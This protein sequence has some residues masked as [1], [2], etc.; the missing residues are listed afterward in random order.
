MERFTGGFKQGFGRIGIADKGPAKGKFKLSLSRVSLPPQTNKQPNQESNPKAKFSTSAGAGLGINK[1]NMTKTRT[2]SVTA[3][4]IMRLPANDE[5]RKKTLGFSF[6]NYQPKSR[7]SAKAT[8]NTVSNTTQV[9][10]TETKLLL[11]KFA[12]N[13]VSK[14]SSAGAAATNDKVF[15]FNSREKGALPLAARSESNLFSS[16]KRKAAQDKKDA[17]PNKSVRCNTKLTCKNHSCTKETGIVKTAGPFAKMI[18]SSPFTTQTGGMKT[19]SNNEAI[20]KKRSSLGTSTVVDQV[21]KR[22]K[23]SANMLSM[24]GTSCAYKVLEHTANKTVKDKYGQE[25]IM[26]PMRLTSDPHFKKIFFRLCV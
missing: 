11:D 1:Q 10:S 23:T 20:F 8:C 7:D 21:I 25:L 4:S 15:L 16:K 19:K 6:M 17:F 3:K 2:S 26:L 13:A 22:S 5:P 24:T 14:K 9:A 18:E 12:V